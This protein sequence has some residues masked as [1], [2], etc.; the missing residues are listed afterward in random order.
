[1]ITRP[2]AASPGS[3]IH[4][5]LVTGGAGF[6]G[7]HTC[8]ELLEHGFD[9][10][11]VDNFSNSSR[12]ALDRIETVAGRRLAG[13]Y[14]LDMR[15]EVSLS[16]VFELHP[17]DAVIHFAAKKAVGESVGMPLEYYDINIGATVQLLKSMV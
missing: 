9:V 12:G 5:I 14:D 3:P 2:T 10:V 13:R 11:V 8:V 15:D 16:A 17:I 4:T 7:S 6:I 1:M